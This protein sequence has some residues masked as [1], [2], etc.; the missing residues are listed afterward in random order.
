[1]VSRFKYTEP[2]FFPLPFHALLFFL[3]SLKVFLLLLY[4]AQT[5]SPYPFLITLSSSARR[6]FPLENLSLAPILTPRVPD[7][8]RTPSTTA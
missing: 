8:A 4:S 7:Q 6:G 5:L 2:I 1:M 3:R